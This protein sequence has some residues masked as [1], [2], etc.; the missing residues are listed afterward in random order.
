MGTHL[1]SRR[2]AKDAGKHKYPNLSKRPGFSGPLTFCD[3]L[4]VGRTDYYAIKSRYPNRFPFIP[5]MLVTAS[6]LDSANCPRLEL[7]PSVNPS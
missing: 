4:L 6:D 5:A 1:K 7:P 2:P 3:G